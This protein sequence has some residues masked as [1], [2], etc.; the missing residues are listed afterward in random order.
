MYTAVR[1]D[2]CTGQMH[3]VLTSIL[4]CP[5]PHMP[6]ELWCLPRRERDALGVHL[7]QL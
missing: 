7:L 4:I 3:A 2:G 5:T 1:E 6:S